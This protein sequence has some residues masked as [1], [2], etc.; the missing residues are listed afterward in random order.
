MPWKKQGSG[1]KV[2]GRG[3]HVRKPKL[4][5]ALRRKGKSK[6]TAAKIANNRKG[7]KK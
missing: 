3:G 4:Y 6:Q 1:Y 7:K 5:E 2:K